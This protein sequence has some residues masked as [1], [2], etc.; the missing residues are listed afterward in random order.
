MTFEELG[1]G[2]QSMQADRSGTRAA[3]HKAKTAVVP[4]PHENTIIVTDFP[5]IIEAYPEAAQGL[6]DGRP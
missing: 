3:W 2:D 1:D 6:S 5:N 4:A